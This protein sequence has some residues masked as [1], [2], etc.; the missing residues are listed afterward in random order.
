MSTATKVKHTPRPWHLHSSSPNDAV[1]IVDVRDR[2]I[3]TVAE[4]GDDTETEGNAAPELLEACKRLLGMLPDYAEKHWS[5]AAS[6]RVTGAIDA[7]RA[8]IDAAEGR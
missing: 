2:L 5:Y 1:R 3:A 8:A 6:N 4:R 7:A